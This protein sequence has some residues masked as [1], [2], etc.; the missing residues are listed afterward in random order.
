M[1]H[2]F[3]GRGLDAIPNTRKMHK[4][5]LVKYNQYAL[6]MFSETT[7]DCDKFQAWVYEP[8]TRYHEV[9]TEFDVKYRFYFVLT[10]MGEADYEYYDANNELHRVMYRY[11]MIPWEEGRWNYTLEDFERQVNGALYIPHHYGGTPLPI[12][13]FEVFLLMCPSAK[14]GYYNLETHGWSLLQP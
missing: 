10:Y 12:D 3:A 13:V 7:A 11:M 4:L 9:I 6:D 2:I 8:S 5:Y 1:E 14:R